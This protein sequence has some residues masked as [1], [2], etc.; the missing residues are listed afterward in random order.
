MIE[1][2]EEFNNITDELISIIISKDVK[3]VTNQDFDN[4]KKDREKFVLERYISVRERVN[5]KEFEI[6]KKNITNIKEFNKLEKEYIELERY[7]SIGIYNNAFSTS[8]FDFNIYDTEN[9]KYFNSIKICDDIIIDRDIRELRTFISYLKS[10]LLKYLD[11]KENYKLKFL[12]IKAV[13]NNGDDFL[14]LRYNNNKNE[15]YLN[16]Q[17]VNQLI[18]FLPFYL[19]KCEPFAQINDGKIEYEENGFFKN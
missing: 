13:T 18:D 5:R 15:V 4:E 17:E 6:I 14:R 9:K 10:F 1:S 12:E 16:K 8:G 7:K 2:R 19:N 11:K 3:Y